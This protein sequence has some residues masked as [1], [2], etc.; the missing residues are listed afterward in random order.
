MLTMIKITINN[1][2]THLPLKKAKGSIIARRKKATELNNQFFNNL[3][4]AF[5]YGDVSL[6][7]FTQILKKHVPQNINL[8]VLSNQ[9]TPFSNTSLNISNNLT[10]NGYILSVP[11]DIKNKIS[12]NNIGIIMQ[13]TLEL[14]ERVLNP[15]Y[16]KR[17]I[18]IINKNLNSPKI[19]NFLNLICSK[20]SL[21]ESDISTSLSE[22]TPQQQIDI[23][24]T[25]RYSLKLKL[26]KYRTGNKYQ[27]EIEKL[28]KHKNEQKPEPFK[29][30]QLQ[31]PQK[32]KLLEK[33]LATIIK[34]ER[35]KMTKS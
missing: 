6:N 9:N 11:T 28:Y 15:K 12:K 19:S 30:T 21:T 29:Y 31:L 10:I 5:A 35:A 22:I 1:A 3:K 16:N 26:N 4:G 33:K 8:T 17:G 20:N 13:S 14:F 24:Q 2:K 25:I 7:I 34:E 23:L 18:D 27:K 32:I